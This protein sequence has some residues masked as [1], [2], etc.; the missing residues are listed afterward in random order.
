VLL[1][2]IVH[3]AGWH[4][5]GWN[6]HIKGLHQGPEGKLQGSVLPDGWACHGPTSTCWAPQALFALA[7]A[8]MTAF[9][10]GSFAAGGGA[11]GGL[12]ALLAGASC[13]GALAAAEKVLG[14]FRRR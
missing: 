12:E 8:G 7:D 1:R 6:A 11:A 14:A 13:G 10:T 5:L 4:W 3:C 9:D 2:C